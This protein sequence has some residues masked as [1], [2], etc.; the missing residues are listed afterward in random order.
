MKGNILFVEN[1][2]TDRKALKRLVEADTFKYQ[3]SIVESVSQAKDALENDRFDVV[4]PDYILDDGTAFD[5]LDLVKDVPVIVVTG[6]GD[7]GIAVKAM[8]AGAYDYIIKDPSRDYLNVLP[9]TIEN[10]INRKKAEVKLNLLESAVV[11]ANDAIIILEAEPGEMMGRQILYV[12]EAFTNMTGY[13]YEEAVRNTLRILRGPRT[14]HAALNKMRIALEQVEPVRVELINYRKD[15]TE[16]WVECNIVPFA[17][18][19]G[20]FVHWVSVQ[21]DITERK[22]AEE[23]KEKLIR[24]IETIN[25]DLTELNRELETIG[26]ERTMSLM[27][28]T[29]ADRIRNPAAMIGGRCRRI[30]QKEELTESLRAGIMNVIEGAEKLDKIVADFEELLRNRQ[31]KFKHEDL[32]RIVEKVVSISGKEA[33]FKGVKMIVSISKEKLRMNMQRDLLRVAIFH[34]MK[35][36]VEATSKGGTVMVKTYKEDDC[37]VLMVSDTGYGI[38]EEDV[39]YVFRPFFST[40]EQGFGMGLPL[41]KQIVAEHL[42]ELIVESKPGKGSTFKLCFP[43]RWKEERLSHRSLDT[44]K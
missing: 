1:D 41:V 42:G 21:R 37:A 34:I 13:T 31:S 7:V 20:A 9:V 4:I 24:E 6:A 27:A 32:N 29:V 35:N 23:E 3:Y 38:P 11:N 26:A 18:E 15:G 12:N 40:K 30:L 10:A 17:D 19:A 14:S 39:E 8:K 28:L 5:I 36:A 44:G 33:L 43:E 22:M 2:A 25:A 16:F